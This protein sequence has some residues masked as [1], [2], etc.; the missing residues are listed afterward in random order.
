[1][2][3]PG[4]KFLIWDVSVPQRPKGEKR[5]YLVWVKITVKDQV[6]ET[7]YVQP[8][9]EIEHNLAFYEGLAEKSGFQVKERRE[10]GQS[11]ILQLQKP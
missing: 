11:L 6:I 8:W 2:L 10:E 9:P 3:K 5:N 7:G 1:M 4:G